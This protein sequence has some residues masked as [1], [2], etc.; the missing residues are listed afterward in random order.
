MSEDVRI[1]MV[2]LVIASAE[3][4]DTHVDAPSRPELCRSLEAVIVAVKASTSS[5]KGDSNEMSVEW[6]RDVERLEIYDVASSINWLDDAD[7]EAKR[8]RRP[9]APFP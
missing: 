7:T 9:S 2:G 3:T 4:C 8:R 5:E 6:R 1:K